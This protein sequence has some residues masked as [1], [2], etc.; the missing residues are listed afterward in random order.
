MNYYCQNF[1]EIIT[2]IKFR[3]EFLK[4]FD[5]AWLLITDKDL[6]SIGERVLNRSVLNSICCIAGMGATGAYFGALTGSEIY[7]VSGEVPCMVSE[8]LTCAIPLVA[9]FHWQA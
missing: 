5:I 7:K 9:F 8:N 1:Y 2:D 4:N 6:K 3:K